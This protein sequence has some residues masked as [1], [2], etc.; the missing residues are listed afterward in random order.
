MQAAAAAACVLR[1]R[2][3]PGSPF[4]L[5]HRYGQYW[6]L[7]QVRDL[8][9]APHAAVDTV[10]AWLVSAGASEL[11][12]AG[13]RDFVSASVP[14]Q[15]I[16]SVLLPGTAMHVWHQTTASG[17]VRR[18]VRSGTGK[19]VLPVHVRA[20]VD[21]IEGVYDFPGNR[22]TSTTVARGTG[23]AAAAMQRRASQAGPEPVLALGAGFDSGAL[24]MASVMCA[25]GTPATEAAPGKLL[26]SANPPA[27]SGIELTLFQEGGSANTTTTVPVSGENCVC[28]SGMCNC[29]LSQ[30]R[31]LN[32]LN[33]S[34]WIR[35]A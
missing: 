6:S 14:V 35:T 28:A 24:V 33:T 13:T 26:C 10:S 19:A 15:G 17:R 31:L 3:E 22:R 30:G 12:V 21:A 18:V 9:A 8:V 32:Y 34:A 20:V 7:E 4:G 25:D 5:G 16:E 23:N 29:N 11:V 1:D 27:V 2:V